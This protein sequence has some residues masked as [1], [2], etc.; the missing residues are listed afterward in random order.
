MWSLENVEKNWIIVR[1]PIFTD[2]NIINTLGAN[3]KINSVSFV[4]FKFVIMF[5]V[6]TVCALVFQPLF[7]QFARPQGWV[8]TWSF[9]CVT[10][11]GG[12][13]DNAINLLKNIKVN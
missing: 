13:K 7:L 11:T 3:N 9:A 5:I 4:Y 10:P 1:A 12:K 8:V 6:K 2:Y